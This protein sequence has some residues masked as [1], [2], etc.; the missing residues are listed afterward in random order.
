MHADCAHLDHLP[1]VAEAA[2]T[3]GAEPNEAT[4]GVARKARARDGP[5]WRAEDAT[6]SVWRRIGRAGRVRVIGSGVM[7]EGFV[8]VQLA[9]NRWCRT[10]I[11]SHVNISQTKPIEVAIIGDDEG[12]SIGEAPVLSRAASNPANEM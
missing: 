1:E 8:V 7:C 11:T 6:S 9:S 2:G 3:E 5:T 4:K 10:M 12:K